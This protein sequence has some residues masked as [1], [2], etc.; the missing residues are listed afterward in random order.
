LR[1]ALGRRLRLATR[2]ARHTLA[3]ASVRTLVA[4]LRLL[5]LPAALSLGAALG[6]LAA[7]ALPGVRAATQARLNATRAA[8]GGCAPTAATHLADLGRRV[9]EFANAERL[10]RLNA[11]RVPPETRA[12][13]TPS[14]RGL[15]V[16]AGH[17][18]NWELMAAALARAGQDVRAVVAA[19]RAGPLSRWLL[20]ER[21]RLGVTSLPPGGG[22]RAARAALASG[23]GVGLLVDLATHERS[24]VVDF[25]GRSTRAALTLERLA[26]STGAPVV[27]IWPAREAG[28]VVIRAEA[29][30]FDPAAP[31]GALTQALARRIEA[32]I[33]AAPERW[34]WVHDRWRSE[35]M[36]EARRA[37]VPPT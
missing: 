34:L 28:A 23:A 21:A 33:V 11:V 4:A 22:A 16:A 7:I 17:L 3:F 10:L 35:S 19:P 25:L 30:G 5:P 1:P 6:R 24:R 15:L 2:P 37:T 20:S 9:A 14:P 13:L 29:V 36:R 31:E 12:L 32:R 26:R 18:D 27:F 8:L